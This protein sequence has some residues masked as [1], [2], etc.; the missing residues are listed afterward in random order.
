MAIHLYCVTACLSRA[1]RSKTLDLPNCDHEILLTK[2]ICDQAFGHCLD[3]SD[4]VSLGKLI[5][6]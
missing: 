2:A 3:L 4:E 5:V 1:T 6:L